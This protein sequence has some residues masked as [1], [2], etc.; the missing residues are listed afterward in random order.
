MPI[1]SAAVDGTPRELDKAILPQYRVE[2]P[3]ILVIEALNL[4]PKP[5]YKLRVLDVLSIQVD[6]TL[7]DAPIQG[8]YPVEPGGMVNLGFPY[9]QVEVAGKG[10]EEAKAAIVETLQQFLREPIV[11]VSL[12]QMAGSQQIA[13]EHLVSPDGTVNLGTYGS[14]VL[15]GM[16]VE[17]ATDAIEQHLTQY[18]DDPE[19]SV[20][21]FAYNSKVYYIV[22]EGAG[23]GDTVTRFPVTGNETVLDAISNV[24]G[25]SS[26]SSHRI[27]IS[28]PTRNP[29]N[30]QILPVDWKAV[31]AQ[32]DPTTNYQIMPGDRIFVAQNKMITFDNNLGKLLAPFERI[33]GFSLLGI[34]TL[35]RFSGRPL[36][37]QGGGFGGG[38]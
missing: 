24:Q 18:L 10:V 28:R 15:V 31:T 13:G 1:P 8:P 27:W 17:E 22:T 21:V 9:G 32:A 26:I 6:G 3:D 23:L 38:F 19:V 5:P 12:L 25:L 2:P 29:G 36:S 33:A 16:T 14:V 20:D 34:G 30:V 35:S 4:V 11:S 7:P 37:R